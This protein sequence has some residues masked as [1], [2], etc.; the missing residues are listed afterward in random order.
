MVTVYNLWKTLSP[1][2]N[3][4]KGKSFSTINQSIIDR[5]VVVGKQEISN[6]TNKHFCDIGNKL[7]SEIPDYR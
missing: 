4:K 2:I 6:S 7:Q 1:I 5:K 3:P